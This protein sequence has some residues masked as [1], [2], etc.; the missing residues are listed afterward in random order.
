MT[1]SVADGN[2][3]EVLRVFSQVRRRT[4][5]A[6]RPKVMNEVGLVEVAAGERHISPIDRA[7]AVNRQQRVLEA[8][9]AAEEL[10]RESHLFREDLDETAR[11]EADLIGYGRHG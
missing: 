8:S 3:V 7:I 10:R 5:P 4:N 1:C 2:V 11:A 9:D 6:E